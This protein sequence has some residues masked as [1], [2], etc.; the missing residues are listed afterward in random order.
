MRV[1]A[2]NPAPVNPRGRFVLYW[3]GAYRRPRWNFALDR[4]IE[5]ARA[6]A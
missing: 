4:A 2:L 6:P 3:M 1:Q 5:W